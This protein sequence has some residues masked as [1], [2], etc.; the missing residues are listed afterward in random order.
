MN[1]IDINDKRSQNEFRQI[2]FSTFQKTK[3]KKE[4]ISCLS[5][6]KIES[7]CYWAAE[8]VCAGHYIDL[9]E[10][11]IEY[12]SK[13][14]HLGNPKLPVYIS[15]RI[16]NFKDILHNG[17][18][19]NE[20]S[21]RNNPKI[22]KLFAEIIGILCF[23]KKKHHLEPVKIKK[24]EEFNMTN[25]SSKLSAP[26]IKYAEEV[27]QKDDPKEIFIAVNEFA[28]C[29]TK[30]SK[31]TI[32]ACYWVEWIMEFEILSKKQKISCNCERRTFAPVQ[33][34]FQNDVIWIIWELLL[35]ECDNQSDS[36]K[37]KMIDALLN[38]FCIRYSSGVKKRRRYLIYFAI[39]ILTEPYNKSENIINK[40]EIVENVIKKID[41]VYK[42]VKKNEISPETDYLFNGVSSAK[43][44]LEKT[45]E[46]LDALNKI[47][48]I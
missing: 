34:K 37:K 30:Q 1:D 21:M 22:R 31:N 7:A 6:G 40:K 18:L 5:E 10:C 2:T 32:S 39:S 41:L 19:D 26:S 20:L 24:N 47:S 33:D 27:F 8:Y 3:V 11:I 16:G 4:L 35:D 25:M 29:I 46:R 48:K 36:S 13:Y 17:Y 9:W 23:S 45:I 43:S 38:I 28:Y 15:M 42:D 44:N 12:M 14:I